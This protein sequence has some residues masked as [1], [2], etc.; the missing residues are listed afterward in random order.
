MQLIAGGFSRIPAASAALDDDSAVAAV[1]DF[2]APACDGSPTAGD[3]DVPAV[4]G[5]ATDNKPVFNSNNFCS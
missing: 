2:P 5:S 1:A 4:F 3:G